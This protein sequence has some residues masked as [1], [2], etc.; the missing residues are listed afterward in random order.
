M[1]LY[2]LSD[3]LVNVFSSSNEAI[4]LLDF[5]MVAI[6]K[7]V[8]LDSHECDK[9]GITVVTETTGASKGHFKSFAYEFFKFT[10]A[11]HTHL[12]LGKQIKNTKV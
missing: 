4:L 1:A 9:S 5:Y 6:M 2:L 10:L 7:N 3:S 11:W 8:F 12:D